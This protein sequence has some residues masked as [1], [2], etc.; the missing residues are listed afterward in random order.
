MYISPAQG[1][2]TYMKRGLEIKIIARFRCGNEE[3]SGEV[4]GSKRCALSHMWDG[5]GD[6]RTPHGYMLPNRVNR[7]GDTIGEGIGAV[8]DDICVREQM[9]G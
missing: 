7:T 1:T 9:G 5:R 3:E 4:E 2:P 8:M 6:H